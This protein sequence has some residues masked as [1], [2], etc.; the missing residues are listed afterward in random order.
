MSSL[1]PGAGSSRGAG[2]DCANLDFR[3]SWPS[4]KGDASVQQSPLSRALLGPSPRITRDE[5]ANGARLLA[6]WTLVHLLVA[7]V[8]TLAATWFWNHTLGRS[9][10]WGGVGV[11][12]LACAGLIL[13]A[14]G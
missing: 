7:L 5:D 2:S 3:R 10:L 11:V 1:R 13:V 8:G 6:S 9:L 4:M 14:Y 12:L